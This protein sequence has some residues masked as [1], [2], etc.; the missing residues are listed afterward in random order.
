MIDNHKYRFDVINTHT[1]IQEPYIGVFNTR[2]EAESWFIEHGLW[3]RK[4]D[5]PLILVKCS[6]KNPEASIAEEED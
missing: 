2:Y 1:G 6:T 4:N 3:H 5:R